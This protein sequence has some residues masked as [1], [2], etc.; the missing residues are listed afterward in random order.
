M[1]AKKTAPTPAVAPAA[2]PAKAAVAAEAKKPV[3]AALAKTA[4]VAQ[5]QAA[6]GVTRGP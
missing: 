1:T 2:K 6:C 3:K 5:A 4:P